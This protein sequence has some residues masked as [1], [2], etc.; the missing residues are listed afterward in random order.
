MSALHCRSASEWLVTCSYY[1]DGATASLKKFMEVGDADGEIIVTADGFADGPFRYGDWPFELA[2]FTALAHHVRN[3]DL[4][5]VF[6]QSE[7][8]EAWARWFGNEPDDDDQVE[9]L[10]QVVLDIPVRLS[11]S[12]RRRYEDG[13]IVY[14]NDLPM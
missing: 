13:T 7:Q 5:A 10:E 11:E 6:E 12:G 2:F 4:E 8:Q 9:R 3:G 1:G 14:L